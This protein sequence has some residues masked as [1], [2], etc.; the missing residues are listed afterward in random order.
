MAEKYGTIPK[1]FTKDWW[2]YFWDYY[3]VHT[4][5]VAGI[6]AAIIITVVQVRSAPKYDLYVTYV[7]DM[8]LSE[9]KAAELTNKLSEQIDD[10]DGDGKKSVGINQYIFSE[11]DVKNN[12]QYFQ[13]IVTKVQLTFLNDDSMLFIFNDKNSNYLFQTDSLE[14]AFTPASEWADISGID[15]D[16]LFAASGSVYGVALSD[17][18]FDPGVNETLYATVRAPRADSDESGKARTETS[19]KLAK[20]LTLG[21]TDK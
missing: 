2:A 21:E 11:D 18:V 9:E 4:L 1:R 3:K 20:Y 5:V 15:K 6:I 8:Y 17:S 7:G 16:K 14:G 19:V 13:A 10:I 12:P